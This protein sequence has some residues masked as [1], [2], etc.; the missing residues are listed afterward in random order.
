LVA[1]SAAQTVVDGDTIK[2]NGTTWRLWGIDTP[3][4]AQTCGDWSAGV[5]ATYALADLMRGKVISC[6]LKDRDR[7]GRSVGRAVFRGYSRMVEKI[8]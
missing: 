5:A 6:E 3:E 1:L 7:Y 4:M 8:T 2:L